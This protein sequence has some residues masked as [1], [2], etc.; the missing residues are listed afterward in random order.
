LIVSDPLT[1]APQTVP[2]Y[3]ARMFEV[4]WNVPFPL[5]ENG[6]EVVAEVAVPVAAHWIVVS[7]SDATTARR[8]R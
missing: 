1:S 2:A 3:V 4:P 8:A 7:P 5:S 6:H